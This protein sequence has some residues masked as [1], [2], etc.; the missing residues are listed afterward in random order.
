MHQKGKSQ[1]WKYGVFGL[2]V[3]GVIQHI[4]FPK[5]AILGWIGI[6][7]FIIGSIQDRNLDKIDIAGR[8]CILLGGILGFSVMSGILQ[9]VPLPIWS[10]SAFTLFG[11]GIVSMCWGAHRKNPEKVTK[12]VVYLATVFWIFILCVWGILFTLR[13]YNH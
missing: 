2:C 10:L 13:Y 5:S 7:I 1:A 6:L 11:I 3:L 4:F 12:K 9:G 8:V